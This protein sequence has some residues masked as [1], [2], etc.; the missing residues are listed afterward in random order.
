MLK[1]IYAVA[2]SLLLAGPSM[3]ACYKGLGCTD[4]DRFSASELRPLTCNTL[5]KMRNAIYYEAGYC[6]K[7]KRAINYFGNDQCEYDDA[8]DLDFSRIEQSNIDTIARVEKRKGC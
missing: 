8:E 1:L 7:T 2:I 4:E 3:A 5:W 6:F